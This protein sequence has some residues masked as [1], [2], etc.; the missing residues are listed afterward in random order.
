MIKLKTMFEKNKLNVK[1]DK[2]LFLVELEGIKQE[3]NKNEKRKKLNISLCIDIS[4]SMDGYI[5]GGFGNY[6]IG[7]FFGQNNLGKESIKKEVPTYK[8]K[9]DLVKEAA[10]NAVNT[11]QNGDI[12]SIVTFDNEVYLNKEATVITK[13]N[14]VDI[15]NI[16]NSI[17]TR[18]S[19]N[20]HGGWLKSVEEVAKNVSSK[21]LNRVVLLTDGQANAGKTNPDEISEDVFN[22]AQKNVSTSTFGVGKSFNETLLSSMSDSGSGNFYFIDDEGNFDVLFNEEFTGMSNVCATNVTIKLD[23]QDGISKEVLTELKSQKDLYY[24]QDLTTTSK[25]PL[26]FELNTK[27]L[28]LG[29]HN[30]GKIKLTYKDINGVENKIKQDIIVN[31]V[32]NKEW[33]KLEEN[34]EIK[35]QEVL[36]TVAKNKKQAQDFFASGNTDEALSML[37]ASSS[38]IACSGFSD[39]R[40]S[41]NLTSINRT[42]K[43][44]KNEDLGVLSKRMH[45]ES[46]RTLKGKDL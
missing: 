5:N 23:L 41:A 27:S 4:G 2:E 43:D 45:Y 10:I 30:I 31:V 22:V 40:L 13:E 33:D 11:M 37:D 46:Y 24:V 9:I 38:A 7:D 34:K 28:K 44:S 3:S 25:T 35:I 12:V 29:E 6:F 1:K 15:I 19:T 14:R 36:M 39:P 16:I 32:S 26:L 18:G 17:T 20:I 42:V 8:R 21:K